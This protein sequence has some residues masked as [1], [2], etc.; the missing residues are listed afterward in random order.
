[1]AQNKNIDKVYGFEDIL[2]SG[3]VYRTAFPAYRVFI[4]GVEITDDVL[5]VS[6]NNSG[7]SVERTA[8]SCTVVLNNKDDRYI[9]THEDMVSIADSKSSYRAYQD[10]TLKKSE[11]D[12]INEFQHLNEDLFDA[13]GSMQQ[14][15]GQT[16]SIE[17]NDTT[18]QKQLMNY[19]EKENNALAIAYETETPWMS[20]KKDVVLDKLGYT[21][22]FSAINEDSDLVKYPLGIGHD[23]QYQEGD[24]I[25]H[26]N[27]PIRVA[28]RD[29]Y[30]SR[31]WYWMFAGFIDSSTEDSDVNKNSTVTITCTDVSKMARYSL[32]QLDTGLYDPKITMET[33][34]GAKLDIVA[35]VGTIPFQ[36]LFEGFTI[37]EI[38]ETI[39]FGTNSSK[40]SVTALVN[41][42]ISGMNLEEKRNYL[43]DTMGVTPDEVD[44]MIYQSYYQDEGA[45]A[46]VALSSTNIDTVNIKIKEYKIG[47][48]LQSMDRA[49]L[50][51]VTSPRGISFRRSSTSIG[52]SYIFYQYNDTEEYDAVKA[53]GVGV[54]DLNEWN[55]LIHHR[56]RESDIRNMLA[57]SDYQVPEESM[58]DSTPKVEDI[59]TLI[60]TN[61][62]RY[63]VGGGRVYYFTPATLD[64]SLGDVL[65]R[66]LGTVGS[67]NSHFRDR[68]SYIY[69]LAER[70][71]FRFY[72]TPKGDLVFEM[73]FYDFDPIDFT[74]KYGI[75]EKDY[76]KTELYNYDGL[77]GRAYQG[78]YD[79]D[80]VKQLTQMSFESVLKD[81]D[82]D[83]YKWQKEAE[84]NWGKEFTIEEHEQLGFSNT[85][86]DVGVLTAYRA[87]Q[88]FFKNTEGMNSSINSEYQVVMLQQLIPTLGFRIGDGDSFGY[89]EGPHAAL[90]YCALELNR[91]N[92]EARNI[93][94]PVM[95]KFGLMVNR[96]ILWRKRNYYANIVSLQHSITWNSG[97]S[98]SVNVNQV[99]G[100][101]GEMDK[102]GRPIHKHFSNTDRPYNLAEMLKQV[103]EADKQLMSNTQAEKK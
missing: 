88:K 52:L 23:Y 58:I 77:F 51:A 43:L 100:W 50:P 27:D 31:I 74:G 48:R 103:K 62:S 29:P 80:V 56:V 91:T 22:K 16:V 6:V 41:R 4:Y 55:E 5:S 7:G 14:T 42:E 47:K 25:F 18:L 21:S 49:N 85:S 54:R 36:E 97:I 40:K 32:I 26:S 37:Y 99:R 63:P 84:F 3:T 71:D 59:I 35:N 38:L 87:K 57:N 39:F 44:K 94:I 83:I 72:A 46:D 53:V 11:L 9:I 82:L 17:S 65:D 61:T 45:A 92:A 8:G 60:G 70:I 12:S 75:T 78:D 76:S 73:P 93:S 15:S 98:T 90:F 2:A 101:N 33:V 30:D 81:T 95:S 28:F 86:T 79:V 10:G 19:K 1:M 66:G 68:L 20:V 102:S 96:P 34:L 67:P 69:D 24:C 64:T 13:I 89:L